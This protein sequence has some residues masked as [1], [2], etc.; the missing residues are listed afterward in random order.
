MDLSIVTEELIIGTQLLDESDFSVLSG[1]GVKGILG[2]QDDKDLGRVGIRFEVLRQVADRYG[3]EYRRCPIRDFD[4]GELVNRMPRCLS[5]LDDLVT[6][7]G[8]SYVHCTAGINRSVGIVLSYLV[9]N[10]H[11]TVKGAYDLIQSVRPQASPYRLLLEHLTMIQ[12]QK[13]DFP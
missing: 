2:L 7:Y 6:R 12:H 8:R 9:L 13:M 11:M 5:E 10:R 3:I 4:P 1:L